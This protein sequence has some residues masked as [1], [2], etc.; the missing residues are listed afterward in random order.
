MPNAGAATLQCT[1]QGEG[2]GLVERRRVPCAGGQK[3]SWRNTPMRDTLTHR[4]QQ[5][6]PHSRLRRYL[7]SAAGWM[8]S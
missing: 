3:S 8:R 1:R 4:A 6:W 2:Q 7:T 5:L